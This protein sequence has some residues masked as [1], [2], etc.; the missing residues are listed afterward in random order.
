MP[1]IDDITGLSLLGVTSLTILL[2]AVDTGGSII[3]AF[4][5]KT[6]STQFLLEYLRSHVLMR[7]FPILALGVLG[8]GVAMLDIPAIP[9]ATL[10][11]GVS[12][13]AYLIETLGSL[14]GSFDGSDAL[15]APKG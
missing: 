11:A 14:K 3:A 2:A 12:L 13:L 5:H 9:A 10:A 6:F 4:I 7:V 1:T 8:H 15:V